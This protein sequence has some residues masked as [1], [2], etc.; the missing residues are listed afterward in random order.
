MNNL[1]IY[2]VSSASKTNKHFQNYPDEIIVVD[3]VNPNDILLD[4]CKEAT[5]VRIA[6][7]IEKNISK[8][9]FKCSHCLNILSENDKVARYQCM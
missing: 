2:T 1:D 3:Q 5:I 6:S 9:N 7:D 8:A 4:A